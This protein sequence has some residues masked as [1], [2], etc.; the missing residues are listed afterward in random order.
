MKDD[1]LETK[2]CRACGLTKPVTHFHKTGIANGN[3]RNARCRVCKRIGL[4]LPKELKRISKQSIRVSIFDD[5]KISHLKDQDYIEVYVWLE[6]Q[7]GYDLRSEKSIH[8]QF[9]ERYGLKIR[10]NYKRFTNHKS[11]KDLGLI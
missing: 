4:L 11:P 5:I 10:K 9:C 2:L 3:R 6:K 8:E 1:V 7:L